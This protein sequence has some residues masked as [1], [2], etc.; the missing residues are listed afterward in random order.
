MQ[1]FNI[2]NDFKDFLFRLVIHSIHIF[3][4]ERLAC[5]Q[6][7]RRYASDLPTLDSP[8]DEVSQDPG[9]YLKEE[10]QSTHHLLILLLLSV[11]MFIVS[12]DIH[13]KADG[14][15][16]NIHN[17]NFSLHGNNSSLSSYI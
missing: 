12:I 16:K 2:Y 4:Q 13:I 6:R 5:R 11:S 8:Q 3:P 15:E 7:L 17:L 9:Q 1:L 14:I 10:Y